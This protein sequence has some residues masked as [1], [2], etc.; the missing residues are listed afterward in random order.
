MRKIANLAFAAVLIGAVAGPGRTAAGVTWHSIQTSGEWSAW[1]LYFPPSP[2][3]SAL[4]TLQSV[5]VSTWIEEDLPFIYFTGEQVASLTLLCT[6]DW[7]N[8]DASGH[9]AQVDT[10]S[11]P[12]WSLDS[13]EIVASASEHHTDPAYG[14]YSDPDYPQFLAYVPTIHV[15]YTVLEQ[16]GDFYWSEWPE[17]HYGGIT[18]T[19]TL[20]YHFTTVPEPAS[21]AMMV[22]GSG[23]IG[24]ALRRRRRG[25]LR[26]ARIRLPQQR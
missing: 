23:V 16:T 19:V 8:W 6:V 12:P 22:T 1:G 5:D 11:L 21:W 4:G 9:F 14:F 10:F 15:D 3:D 25:L 13:F 20:V 24:A 18:A 17:G 2:F 26:A 7:S